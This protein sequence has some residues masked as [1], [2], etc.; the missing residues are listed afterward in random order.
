MQQV[1][2]YFL[3]LANLCCLHLIAVGNL[4][5]LEELASTAMEGG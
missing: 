4:K 5:I 1:G 2:S 3:S